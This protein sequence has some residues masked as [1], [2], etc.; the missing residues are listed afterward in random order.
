MTALALTGCAKK[1]K[2]TKSTTEVVASQTAAITVAEEEAE[3]S[4]SNKIMVAEALG[5]EPSDRAVDKIAASLDAIGT[6]KL[7]SATKDT[8][9]D[10]VVLNIVA[11][12]AMEFRLYLSAY[13]MK[14][15]IHSGINKH[16]LR[17]RCLY[18]GM[19]NDN[20]IDLQGVLIR[21]NRHKCIGIFGNV[22]HLPANQGIQCFCLEKRQFL[23]REVS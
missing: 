21:N 23:S 10:E 11:E 14:H 18:A 8:E 15:G 16:E 20:K 5:I 6:G 22:I 4:A 17:M 12:D 7:Q 1:N 3:T 9:N 19:N 13:L 2:V